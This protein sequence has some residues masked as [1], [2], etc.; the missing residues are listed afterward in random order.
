VPRR[1][2]VRQASHQH[3]RAVASLGLLVVLVVALAGCSTKAQR[4]YRLAE[5]FFAGAKYQLAETEYEKV[6]AEDRSGALAEAAMYKIA[7]IYREVQNDP[8]RAVWW[9]QRLIGDF[10]ESS[11]VDDAY[12]WVIGIQA[13][14]LR[15]L[16]ATEAT[17]QE[18]ER[19]FPEN[20]ATCGRA[21]LQYAWLLDKSGRTPAAL[22]A[23]QGVMGRPDME[24]DIAAGAALLLAQI[25]QRS[26]RDPKS[27]APLFEAVI[28]NYPDTVAAVEAKQAIGW[29]YYGVKTREAS[30][31]RAEQAR[32]ARVLA[33]V[34]P[35]ATGDAQ[36][37]RQ[38][39]GALRSMLAQAGTDLSE[40][41][42]WGISGA[43]FQFAYDPASPGVTA[44]VSSQNPLTT[45]AEELGYTYG[46]W[47]QGVNANA[48]LT[49]EQSLQSERPVLILYSD[50]RPRWSLV[51]GYKPAERAVFVITPG[52]GSAA[53]VTADT[54]LK[55]WASAPTGGLWSPAANRGYQ[56]VLGT[57]GLAEDP[58]VVARHTLA[59]AA[60]MSESAAGGGVLS[61]KAAYAAL[62]A[63]IRRAGSGDAQAQ[64][65]V[66]QW[67]A[68]PLQGH[69]YA[70]TQAIRYLDGIQPMFGGS[71]LQ[72]VT[73]AANRYDRLVPDWTELGSELR[74]AAAA[75]QGAGPTT[76]AQLAARAQRLC[77]EE[78][79][80][81]ESLA[82]GAR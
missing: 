5:S 15:D 28:R 50:G 10:P 78:L 26:A 80:A 33:G 24:S 43:A 55:R 48:L 17:F 42:I 27:A 60:R 20:A 72:A 19:R 52:A 7:Y 4:R 18:I 51:T 38:L 41:A 82:A 16:A 73:S 75:G 39:I 14:R 59:R 37:L 74:A 49:I 57:R 66:G 40:E 58:E 54:F 22:A 1:R 64:A 69:I 13:R 67:A 30:L 65:L 8:P 53:R 32:R 35:F 12:L 21:Q 29:T 77:D 36:P 56:F 2:V 3:R 23:C 61:G 63:T 44:E 6:I 46:V 70:R 71:A 45:V 62:V 68:R 25:T 81:L 47:S 34:A 11:Y 76:W 79:A 9:Y 31:Q